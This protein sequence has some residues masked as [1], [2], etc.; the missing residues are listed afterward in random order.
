MSV[1]SAG[2]LHAQG[3]SEG[4][5]YFFSR[6]VPAAEIQ[7][8]LREKPYEALIRRERFESVGAV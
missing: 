6:P 8:L 2:Y 1:W 4:Q 7:V 3:C 5:G